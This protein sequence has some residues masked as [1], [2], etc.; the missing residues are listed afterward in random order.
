MN[1]LHTS[2]SIVL[3]TC[4]LSTGTV[5]HAQDRHEHGEPDHHVGLHF[6]HPMFTESIS[7]DRK[8]R[9]SFS[10]AWEADATELEGEFE[11]EY[12]IARSFSVE[13]GGPYTIVDPDGA[14]S[15]SNLGNLEIGLK[16]ANYAFED[17]G[18]LLGYGIE[19]GL[20]TGDDAKGIGSDHVFEV[21]PFFNAGIRRDHWEL[22]G[23]SR[24]GIP[25]NQDD[26]EEV[27][28]E[29]NYDLSFMYHLSPRVQ[30]LLELNGELVSSGEEAGAGTVQLAP[31]LR[32][33]PFA[34]SPLFLGAS[35]GMPIDEP[36]LDA[37][38]LVSLFYHF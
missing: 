8:V 11:V 4:V 38:L 22:V 36:E 19:F 29:F 35:V 18:I 7:P 1:K 28:T 13:L 20:P 16:F 10:R 12:L 37:R 24:F 23:F 6:S 9:L 21:E 31:G 17:L 34:N 15:V 26:G 5:V 14:S 30:A 25:T 2:F 3:L 27:E 32:F 33:A